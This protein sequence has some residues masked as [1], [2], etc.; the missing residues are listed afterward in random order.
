MEFAKLNAYSL[1]FERFRILG[2]NHYALGCAFLK[3]SF[4][5]SMVLCV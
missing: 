4:N 2:A 3:T 5:F 1:G